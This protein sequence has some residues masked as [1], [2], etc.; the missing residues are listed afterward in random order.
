MV[1][2]FHALYSPEPSFIRH[3]KRALGG[4]RVPAQEVVFDVDKET[5]D[6]RQETSKVSRLL[7]RP[8]APK[9]R[10]RKPAKTAKRRRGKAAGGRKRKGGRRRSTPASANI[11]AQ[12]KR[13]GLLGTA[14]RPIKKRGGRKKKR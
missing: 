7:D 3:S 1:F 11:Y 10:R 4:G 12:I 9:R 14:R 8:T 5:E 13:L 6:S 2:G